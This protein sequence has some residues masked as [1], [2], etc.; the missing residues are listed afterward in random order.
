MKKQSVFF[1]ALVSAFAMSCREAADNTSAA[2][3]LRQQEVAVGQQI[4]LATAERWISFYKEES[5]KGR[6]QDAAYRIDAA[7]LK[8]LLDAVTDESGF[9]LHHAT[10][11]EG[12]HHVLITAMG[13]NHNLWQAPVA[14][15]N[16]GTLLPGSTAMAWAAKYTS[17]HV[18]Q[19]RYHFFGMDV[20]NEISNNTAFNYMDIVPAL[21]DSSEPQLLMMVWNNKGLEGGRTK[22][23]PAVVYDVS[24]PCPP[25]CTTGI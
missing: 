17:T 16:T 18:G 8:Q 7:M 9:A 25:Y 23:V 20:F 4:P 13:G 19:I 14:D 5:S 12:V 1:A 10:D 2:T 11:E 24:S 15:A 22:E 3:E 6:I 21:N